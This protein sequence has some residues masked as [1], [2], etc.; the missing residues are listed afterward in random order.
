MSSVD[1]F[2]LLQEKSNQLKKRA[3]PELVPRP[4]A[5]QWE[6]PMQG[7]PVRPGTIIKEGKYIAWCLHES[8]FE[9]Q[10]ASDTNRCGAVQQTKVLVELR[11]PTFSSHGA[12][13][14][15]EAQ[16]KV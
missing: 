4:V 9:A 8:Y 13:G 10:R 14:A 2:D 11:K 7:R 16:K 3:K 5:V 6:D 12:N 1:Y 15:T